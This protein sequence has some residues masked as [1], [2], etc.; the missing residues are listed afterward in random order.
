MAQ[1]RDFAH[2]KTW[3]KL[4]VYGTQPQKQDQ[5]LGRWNYDTGAHTPIF[6]DSNNEYSVQMKRNAS[7]SDPYRVSLMGNAPPREQASFRQCVR[8]TKAP[9]I[10]YNDMFGPATGSTPTYVLMNQLP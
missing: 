6:I 1:L 4:Y 5:E 7:V 3:S 10:C 8:N 2:N 9:F